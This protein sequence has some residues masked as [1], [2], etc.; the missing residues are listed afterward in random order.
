MVKLE[1]KIVFLFGLLDLFLKYPQRDFRAVG[2]KLPFNQSYQRNTVEQ[3][4]C[5]VL[6]VDQWY[7]RFGSRARI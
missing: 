5:D 3:C 6:T 1:N 7:H 4:C 2:L